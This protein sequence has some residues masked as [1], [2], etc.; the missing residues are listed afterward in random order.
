MGH[1]DIQFVQE[2]SKDNQMHF[3]TLL[4]RMLKITLGV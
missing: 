2:K 4:K 3:I 1:P